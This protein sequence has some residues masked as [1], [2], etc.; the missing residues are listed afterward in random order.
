MS[1]SD[2][3]CFAYVAVSPLKPHVIKFTLVTLLYRRVTRCQ[4]RINLAGWEIAVEAIISMTRFY[5]NVQM[6]Q[7]DLGIVKIGGSLDG[8]NVVGDPKFIVDF[9]MVPPT[10][11][12]DIE[13]AF[14]SRSCNRTALSKFS[15]E[16]KALSSARE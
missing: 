7:I 2:M 11:A 14:R 4:G 16:R 15:L 8:I 6:D 9:N 1:S 3:N 13:G 10:A 5:I 12:I